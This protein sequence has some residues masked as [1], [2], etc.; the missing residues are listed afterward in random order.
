MEF[1]RVLFRSGSLDAPSLRR[2]C[3]PHRRIIDDWSQDQAIIL[4]CYNLALPGQRY[5]PDSQGP[6][7]HYGL[8]LSCRRDRIQIVS[9]TF[10]EWSVLAAK[11]ILVVTVCTQG[12]YRPDQARASDGD[13][14]HEALEENTDRGRRGR[15]LGHYRRHHGPSEWQ[16]CSHGAEREGTTRRLVGGGECIRRNQAE[17]LPQHP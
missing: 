8:E 16:E 14:N 3:P 1:R 15:C 2:S 4:S 6:G 13:E 5:S 10:G 7:T 11:G 17:E 12:R 9:L